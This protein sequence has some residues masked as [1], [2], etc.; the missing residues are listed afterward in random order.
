MLRRGRYESS[1]LKTPQ[2][3]K[4]CELSCVTQQKYIKQSQS[5]SQRRL[6]VCLAEC[7]C[8]PKPFHVTTTTSGIHFCSLPQN[9]SFFVFLFFLKVLLSQNAYP[10]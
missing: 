9:I 3:A 2:S 1:N 5:N 10:V 4:S 6:D 8:H 7:G